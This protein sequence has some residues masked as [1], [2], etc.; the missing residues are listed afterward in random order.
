MRE[1]KAVSRYVEFRNNLHTHLLGIADEV[2]H[3][4]FR[5]AAVDCSKAREEVALHSESSLSIVPIVLELVLRSVV[6]EV[7]LKGIHLVVRHHIDE[8]IEVAQRVELASAVNHKATN[9]VV[10]LVGNG[11][12]G[13]ES[14]INSTRVEVACLFHLEQRLRAP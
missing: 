4:L 2:A 11:E 8:R 5:I 6:V 14:L 13:K 10:G 7:K 1:G 12:A 3:L 9:G